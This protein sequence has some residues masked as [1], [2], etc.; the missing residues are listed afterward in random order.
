M[1]FEI[2]T[3][4]ASPLLDTGFKQLISLD[5]EGGDS[6]ALSILNSL[7]PDF[8]K[9]PIKSLKSAPTDFWLD[10]NQQSRSLSVDFHAKNER[11]E[12]I[13]IEM[14]LRRHIGFDE[15]A[16]FSA[17]RTYSNQIKKKEIE[18]KS[19]HWFEHL[20]KTYSIQIVN[21][22][23]ENLKGIEN[24]NM[25]D[26][27]LERAEK[28]PMLEGQFI[29][30]YLMTD[31]HSGQEIDHLQMI[32]IELPRADTIMNL[33][34]PR[35]DFTTQEWWL[36]IFNHAKKYTQEYIE[37]LYE[38][39]VMQHEIYEGLGRMKIDKWNPGLVES[40]KKDLEEIREFYA[41][42]IV[43]DLNAARKEGRAEGRAEGRS[44]REREM[45]R[46]A[47]QMG[48]PINQVSRLTGLS[49]KELQSL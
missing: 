29:K 38:E 44:E 14:Q 28:H 26:T 4:Y 25:K 42:Q 8:R 33:F 37:K 13:I 40:Y 45:A 23:S 35:R 31:K 11:G 30:H 12:S 27:L 10:E 34:P 1:D 48:I 46:N 41:P 2:T 32:Q 5:G 18:S 6:V 24:P 7:V 39:G 17:T 3:D 19:G 43:M 22:D 9:N 47:L 21:Y 20:K 36:S 16:L 15:R 49:E